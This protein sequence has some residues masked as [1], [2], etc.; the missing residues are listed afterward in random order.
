LHF[1]Q[2]FKQKSLK[3]SDITLSQKKNISL[4]II[5][6]THYYFKK[7]ATNA[8]NPS[9]LGSGDQEDND[10]GPVQAKC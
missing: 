4:F 7:Q 9:Y 8:C 2:V 1:C 3:L 5:M 6:V 10:L